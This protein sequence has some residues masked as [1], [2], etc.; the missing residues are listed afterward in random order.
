V[1]VGD[2]FAEKLL[3]EASLELIEGGLV[4]GLQDL[5]AAGI[6]CAVSETADRA[7][8]GILVD[9]DVIPL[10]ETGM[11]PAE[12]MI[13]ESQERMLAIVRP[14]LVA[15]VEAVCRRWGINATVIGRVTDDGAIRIVSGATELARIPA[16]ALTS[17]AIVYQREARPPVHERAAPAPGVNRELIETEPGL[18]ERGM[19]PG[20]V[21]LALLGHPNLCSRAWLT[22]QYDET[23]GADTVEGGEHGAAV[24]RVRGT[25]R[26]LVMATDACA[27]VAS[28]DPYLGAALAVAECTRNVAV[29]GAR[30]LGVTDCLNYGDPGRPE[31][32]WAFTEAIRG[33]AD[34]C[35]AL[36]LPVTGGNVSFYNE[37]GRG[38]IA[39]TAQIGVVG[40]LDDIDR[41][42]GPVFRSAGDVIGLLGS[43][44]PGLAGSVYASLAGASLDDRPPGLE[45]GRERALQELLIEAAAQGL[46]ASAQDVSG[47]GLAIAIAE[48]CIW[49]GLG[50]ELDLAVGSTPA[51]EL[52]GEAPSRVVVSA[53]PEVWDRL[54]DLAAGR[55]V[56]LER[57]GRVGGGRLHIRL[58]G[59]AATGA[60]EERGAGVA[61]D[62]DVPVGALEHAWT[63][64]LPRA[65][66]EE[67]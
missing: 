4:E 41:R 20:A 44:T 30:P 51:L 42:V 3:I 54:A 37:S 55:G 58:I 19:D 46:L 49:S 57:M 26:A 13:S 50:A 59:L 38:A 29:T 65:L 18:P 23:V 45:L 40:L 24:L 8:T 53:T 31:A 22:T 2:P 35:R 64:G 63:A 14:A 17:D 52:F 7:G 15:D 60:A 62:V 56:P 5:G 33:V 27:G 10:R 67:A 25:P 36:E 11:A 21:L 61:D 28:L 6:T 43:T 32:F 1:Q 47:G 66:G 9:L 39:P 12:V 48:G 34:A 16:A